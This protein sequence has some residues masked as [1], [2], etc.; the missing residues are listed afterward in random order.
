MLV[1]FLIAITVSVV[2]AARIHHCLCSRDVVI[3][4]VLMS[5]L[6]SE[7]VTLGGFS[8]LKLS[9][10]AVRSLW[11]LQIMFYPSDRDV[12]GDGTQTMRFI[13]KWTAHTP[14]PKPLNPEPASLASRYSEAPNQ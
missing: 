7:S 11:P 2:T 1:L 14:N 9:Y 12:L 3:I 8:C 13:N 6:W 5:K 4:R 10:D